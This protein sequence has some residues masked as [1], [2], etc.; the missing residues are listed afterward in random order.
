MKFV[1]NITLTLF[2]AAWSATLVQA[3]APAAKLEVIPQAETDGYH[4]SYQGASAGDLT[5]RVLSEEDQVL[6]REVIG[7]ELQVERIYRLT[8]TTP[9]T[10][11]FE[12]SG[13]DGTFTQPVNYPTQASQA[14]DLELVRDPSQ[15]RYQ[16]LVGGDPSH[17]VQISIYD[18]DMN[19][20]YTE[21]TTV[22]E[23]NSKVY[24]LAQVREGSVL[25][26]VADKWNISERLIPRS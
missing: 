15:S 7:N 4:L 23:Q 1:L 16:V 8:E 11:Y 10:Y 5:V 20:L 13:P 25:F 3:Q 17:E 22:A 26:T 21:T 2:V 6:H 18:A 9:G 12:V 24:N 19:Q 14:L